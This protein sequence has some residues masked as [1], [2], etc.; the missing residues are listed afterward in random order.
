MYCLCCLHLAVSTDS[1]AVHGECERLGF[2]ARKVDVV[3]SETN[4]LLEPYGFLCLARNLNRVLQT[5]L[6][7]ICDHVDC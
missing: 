3:Y 7:A 4:N 1:E 6:P 2:E 5:V